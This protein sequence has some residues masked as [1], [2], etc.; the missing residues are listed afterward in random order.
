MIIQVQWLPPRAVDESITDTMEA[1]N[2][3]CGYTHDWSAL[4]NKSSLLLSG[5]VRREFWDL[6]R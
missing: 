2:T 6:P 3:D 4:E 1:G 5:L